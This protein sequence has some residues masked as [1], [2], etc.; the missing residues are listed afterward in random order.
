MLAVGHDGRDLSAFG[1]DLVL[2]LGQSAR[3]D[4]AIGAPMAAMERDGDGSFVQEAVEADQS[5]VRIRENEIRH[6]LAGL[7]RVLADLMLFQPRDETI[8]RG[9]KMRPQP[10]HRV[11]E[12][13]QPLGQGRVHVAALDEG[14]VELL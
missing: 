2:R 14:F 6:L 13:L 8:D 11:G 5:A 12:G 9:L 1:G 3:V 4:A 7:R 10:P